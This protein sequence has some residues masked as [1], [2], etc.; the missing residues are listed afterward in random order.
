MQK[1]VNVQENVVREAQNKANEYDRNEGK[2]KQ[3]LYKA[4]REQTEAL[5][6]LKDLKNQLGN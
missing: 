2:P 3:Q 1:V 6:E 5:R 4:M